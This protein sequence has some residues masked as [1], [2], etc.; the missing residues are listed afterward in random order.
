MGE[1]NSRS[2]VA[3]AAEIVVGIDIGGTKVALM[4]AEGGGERE[5]ARHRFATPEG[6]DVEGMLALLK[7]EVTAMLRDAGRDIAELAAIGAAVPGTV[8][9]E[10]HL[11]SAGNLG[12]SDFPFRKRLSELFGAPAFV[13]HDANAAA[14]GERWRGH[15]REM[16][17]FVF[18]ALGT[19]IGAGLFLDGRLYRGAHH[20]AGELGDLIVGRRGL[21]KAPEEARYLSDI[22]GSGAIREKAREASGEDLDAAESLKGADGD[23]KLKRVADEV[24]DYI[25]L[26]VNSII[27]LV[28]PEAIIFGGG[29]SSAGDELIERVGERLR[30]KVPTMPRLLRSALD[31]DAQLYGAIYGAR[32]ARG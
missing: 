10:G 16:D 18:L 11:I 20:A 30:D 7:D 3:R 23:R 29:T 25:A 9:R 5:V 8:N 26:A 17:N 28:D 13:E 27:T 4:G 31:E 22:I 12:W 24:I 32:A 2:N 6:I 19:G 14:L 15:A 21:G 1:T